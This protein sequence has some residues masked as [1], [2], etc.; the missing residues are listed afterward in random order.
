MLIEIN[1]SN[2]NVISTTTYD[3]AKYNSFTSMTTDG[4]HL[5]VAGVSGSSASQDQAVLLTYDIGGA[6]T[7]SR[8]P[9]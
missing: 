6:T 1:P 7:T 4:H 3:A 8:T 5:Y 9:R 2:G